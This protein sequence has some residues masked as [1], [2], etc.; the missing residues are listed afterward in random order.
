M[1]MTL[2]TFGAMLILIGCVYFIILMIYASIISDT[3]LPR[4]LDTNYLFGRINEKI[5]AF[6]LIGG[7]VMDII[8]NF[9]K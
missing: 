4:P 3:K 2:N 5:L 6:C 7:I 9:V 8:S 1:I